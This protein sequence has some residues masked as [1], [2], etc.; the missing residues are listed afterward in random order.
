MYLK[1][2][3]GMNEELREILIR[4]FSIPLGLVIVAIVLTLK[5][6]PVKEFFALKITTAKNSLFWFLWYIPVF[7][8]C[9]I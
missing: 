4:V 9:E 5:K 3:N 2:N 7:I 8:L 6:Q 1:Y